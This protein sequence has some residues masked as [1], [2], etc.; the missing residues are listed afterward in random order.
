MG[1]DRGLDKDTILLVQIMICSLVE[2][3]WCQSLCT[4]VQRFGQAT[5][6]VQT[7]GRVS[8]SIG[9]SGISGVVQDLMNN[10]T[11]D[12]CRIKLAD[13]RNR[14]GVIVHPSIESAQSAVRS[15]ANVLLFQ[16]A[17]PGFGMCADV[18]DSDDYDV[19]PITA[20][21][22]RSTSRTTA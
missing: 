12:P 17:C 4:R 21:T 1:R 8:N 20:M 6:V 14:A 16:S 15:R 9:Y 10:K 2:F 13:M 18:L 22:V 3:V 7:V 11:G 19:W 5:G